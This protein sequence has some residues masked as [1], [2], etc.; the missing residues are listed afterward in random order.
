M[1]KNKIKQKAVKDKNV[2]IADV[3]VILKRLMNNNV[4]IS[5]NTTLTKAL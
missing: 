5:D 2:L 3:S 1:S 4:D